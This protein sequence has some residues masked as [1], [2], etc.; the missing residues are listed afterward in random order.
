MSL[1][2]ICCVL[3]ISCKKENPSETA[4]NPVMNDR[5][6]FKTDR[7][8]P[9]N[10]LL[11]S[12]PERTDS[13]KE[14]VKRLNDIDRIE[15]KVERIQTFESLL[16]ENIGTDAEALIDYAIKDLE[17]R[18]P[19]SVLPFLADYLTTTEEPLRLPAFAKLIA[20]D[21]LDENLKAFFQE[22]L[23]HTLNIEEPPAPKDWERLVNVH[24]EKTQNLIF[25]GE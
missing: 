3:I 13:S 25:S 11:K 4:E 17:K 18:G 22:E 19:D 23:M 20:Q 6:S 7:I 5:R 24:L 1:T 10:P 21:H 14:I 12:Q 16:E 9:E 2:L 8:N 15:Q